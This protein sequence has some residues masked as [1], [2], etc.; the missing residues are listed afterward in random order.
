VGLNRRLTTHRCNAREHAKTPVQFWMLKYG[1]DNIEIVELERADDK[2]HL[3]VLE[4]FWIAQ[5][6]DLN[7]MLNVTAGGDGAEGAKHTEQSKA[8]IS[9]ANR[10]RVKT[11]EH[12]ANIS[13]GMKGKPRTEK[14]IAHLAKMNAARLAKKG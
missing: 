8:K 10:G 13:E 2:S 5:M 6:R 12:R 3:N 14:Q 1:L 9:A 4:Q 7:P 11:A